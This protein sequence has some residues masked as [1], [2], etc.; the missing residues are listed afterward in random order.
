MFRLESHGLLLHSSE[1]GQK[2]PHSVVR[3]CPRL[4]LLGT[5][6]QRN[7][8]SDADEGDGRNDEWSIRDDRALGDAGEFATPYHTHHRED[9]CFYVLDRNVAFVCNGEWLE[10]GPGAFMYGPRDIAHGFKAIG[11][12]PVRMLV[13]C[14]PAGFERFVL[15]QATPIA[16]KGLRALYVH[17][18]DFSRSQ[19][20]VRGISIP[21]H[22]IGSGAGSHR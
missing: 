10:A 22:W 13:M 3:L 8:C 16:A 18:A 5:F 2:L 1:P 11:E 6:R 14:T 17:R 15:D 20:P 9:E 4:I 12:R 19:I 7:G 21:S